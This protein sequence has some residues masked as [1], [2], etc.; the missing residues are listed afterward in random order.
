[1]TAAPRGPHARVHAAT[2]ALLALLALGVAAAPA[3]QARPGMSAR[4]QPREVELGQSSRLV[5]TVTG[6]QNAP[7]PRVAQIDGLRLQS[8]GQTTSVHI[9]NGE[10]NAE[11]THTFLIEPTRTGRFTIPAL[12]MVLDGERLATTPLVLDVVPAGAGSAQRTRPDDADGEARERKPVSLQLDVPRRDLYVG[13]LVPMELRLYVREDVRVTEVTAPVLAGNAFTVSRPRDGQPAQTSEII[14][15]ARYVVATFPLAVSP[16]TAGDHV[17]E[18]KLDLSAYLPAARRRFG[19]LMD[20][21]FFESFFGGRGPRKIP[22]ASP[23]RSVRVLPLP[24]AGR[25]PDFSGA[26]GRFS[27]SASAAPKQVTAGDPV[28]LTVVVSGQGNFDRVTI[29]ALGTDADWKTYAASTKFEPS[30]ELGWAGRKVAEQAIVPQSDGVTA[31]P[32]RPFSYFDPETRRYVQLETEPIALAVVASPRS[33]AKGAG[34]AAAGA[35]V[36]TPEWELVPNHIAPGRLV[37]RAEPLTAQPWFLALQ[38]VP[39]LALAAATLWARRRERLWSDPAHHR[40]IAARRRVEAEVD[41]MRRAAADGDTQAFFAAARRAVQERLGAAPARTA[42]SLT[43]AEM[44]ALVEPGSDRLAEL[45]A[46]VGQADAVAYSGELLPRERLAAWQ[47][48][49][50]ALLRALDGSP[51][52]RR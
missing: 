42:E 44:E 18:A 39:L 24:D 30:D 6:V 32:S 31:V 49:T 41:A 38:G 10:V 17:L 19:G 52:R 35:A 45:R 13:E 21:P 28:T 8:L 4:L 14:D 7:A 33:V 12:S 46:I 20:D 36:A 34:G 50:L 5:V 43:L 40:R 16:V 25:P 47:E 3:A 1:M 26:I 23:A 37:E 9:V 2:F 48:R 29:P 22:L 27:V 11:V 15:G 51:T